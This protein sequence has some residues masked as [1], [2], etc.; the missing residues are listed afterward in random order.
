MTDRMTSVPFNDLSRGMARDRAALLDA[1]A[2]V[3]D[4]GYAIHGAQHAAFETEL[5]EYL[6]AHTALGVATGTDALELAIKAVM[7]AGR[8]VVIT[9][10][11]AGAYTSTA[12]VRAGFTPRYADI[13]PDTL[14]LTA[15][16]VGP[17]LDDSVGVVVVT[18]LYGR[19]GDAAALRSLCDAHGIALVEDCAQAIGA[20]D[21]AGFAGTF[22]HA[23]TLSFYPT[24][25]LGAIGDGGAVIAGS[26][27]V[28]DRVRH[29]RQYG[30]ETKYRATLAGGTNSR[31]D[32][33]QAAFLRI[34][35]R[36]IDELN[37]RR[38][39]IVASYVEAASDVDPATLTVLP[40]AGAAHVAHLAVARSGQRDEVRAALAA[41]GVPTDVH[42]PHP[43]WTQPA[44]A[45]H[46]P[47]VD[48][49]ATVEACA[50]VVS[51]PLFAELRDDEVDQVCDAIRALR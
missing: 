6:G 45:H 24:K 43:D 11:N 20:R 10:G 7:P 13:D 48:L 14:C 41:A 16:T 31:L 32:E 42:F 44:F 3:I 19:L 28:A 2:D 23:A 17:R 9:A 12:T 39:Q 22:G 25:N 37:E 4:S 27:E 36:T 38:R 34:R 50:S 30:W 1:T 33:L 35:L 15:E 51:L 49:P 21:A 47:D 40:A 18:H 8:N 26:D 5:A 46:A 29:L